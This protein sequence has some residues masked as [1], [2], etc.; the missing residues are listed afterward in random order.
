MPKP[1]TPKLT[2]SV[3]L[4]NPWRYLL[5]SPE[6]EDPN[7]VHWEEQESSSVEVSTNRE[8]QGRQFTLFPQLPVEIQMTIARLAN[9]PRLI[10]L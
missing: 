9:P 3:S 1:Y 4:F 8:N 5:S 2:K 7:E 10:K 6:D